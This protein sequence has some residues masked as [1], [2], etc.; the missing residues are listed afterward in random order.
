MFAWQAPPKR[1]THFQPT[2]TQ[3]NA[4]V[5]GK[6]PKGG[7]KNLFL[8]L[9]NHGHYYVGHWM[10]SG[11]GDKVLIVFVDGDTSHPIDIE[12][13]DYKVWEPLKTDYTFKFSAKFKERNKLPKTAKSFKIIQVGITGKSV[14]SYRVIGQVSCN[15][16]V[17][18]A[19]WFTHW[20]I[21]SNQLSE[22]RVKNINPPPEPESRPRTPDDAP[23]TYDECVKQEYL[24][25]GG[26]DNIY[27]FH[28]MGRQW[29]AVGYWEPMKQEAGEKLKVMITRGDG[30]KK[31]KEFAV[32]DLDWQD[33][34]FVPYEV[35]YE[36]KHMLAADQWVKSWQIC[37]VLKG[38][39]FGWYMVKEQTK[40]R[41]TAGGRSSRAPVP[42]TKCIPYWVIPDH[43]DDE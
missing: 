9:W 10:Q 23:T 21:V 13:V 5:A 29:H 14:G 42:V 43:R 1:P 15:K 37:E 36:F 32:D 24:P 33:G 7:P 40:S 11:V 22:K 17:G 39:D 12:E 25:P 41:R 34:P 20:N 38:D 16:K 8:F 35:G 31:L 28:D 27:V 6:L 2:E 30:Q 18:K 3:E 26:K 19:R 4:V